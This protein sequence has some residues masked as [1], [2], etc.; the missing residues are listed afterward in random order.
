MKVKIKKLSP[1][2]V[3]PKYSKEGD[4]GLDLVATSKTENALY[5]EYGTSLSFELSENYVGLLYPRSSLSNYH[6]VLANHVGIVDSNFRGEVK[7]R[8][9]KTIDNSYEKTYNIGDRIA[10]LVIMPYP[11]VELVEVEELSDTARGEKGFGSSGV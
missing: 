6:L 2:A 1:N 4:A 9:K 11:K 7:L 3:I 10:Q 5:I 8:F